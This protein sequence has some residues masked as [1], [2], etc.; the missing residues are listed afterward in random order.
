MPDRKEINKRG[1]LKED[2]RLSFRWNRRKSSFRYPRLLISFRSSIFRLLSRAMVP[3]A[4]RRQGRYWL[5]YRI[6]PVFTTGRRKNPSDLE[7]PA[8]LR[9]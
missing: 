8:Q 4:R 1:Y 9:D 3:A 7:G 6:S 5:L 2:F